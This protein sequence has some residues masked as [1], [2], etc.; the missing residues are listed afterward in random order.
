[1][2]ILPP[3][4]SVNVHRVADIIIYH[5]WRIAREAGSSAGRCTFADD[6]GSHLLQL[7]TSSLISDDLFQ[8][9]HDSTLL[10]K[11]R[12]RHEEIGTVS[13]A[14]PR[15]FHTIGMFL[16]VAVS[17]RSRSQDL[18]GQGSK[19]RAIHLS[20]RCSR[21]CRNRKVQTSAPM[22]SSRE[23]RTG[24]HRLCR[25]NHRCCASHSASHRKAI[26]GTS[27][28]MSGNAPRKAPM[29]LCI[30]SESLR[31]KHRGR[32]R[33]GMAQDCVARDETSIDCRTREAGG[34]YRQCTT[35]LPQPPCETTSPS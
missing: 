25:P 23:S 20:S 11:R 16:G 8:R 12:D 21:T 30:R 15:H 32:C 22:P 18:R 33:D 13:R 3:Q 10:I 34:L 27:C 31:R 28:L 4:V 2:S 14:K 5:K 9:F 1:M 17:G 24:S 26:L 7:L 19:C 6:C 35:F 29:R